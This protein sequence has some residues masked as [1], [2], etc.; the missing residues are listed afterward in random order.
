VKVYALQ[1]FCSSTDHHAAALKRLWRGAGEWARR[2]LL[3]GACSDDLYSR[4]EQPKRLQLPT[5]V[6][7]TNRLWLQMSRCAGA[8]APSMPRC[9]GSWGECAPWRV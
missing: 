7:V 1:P 5:N 2:E 6:M 9:V 8:R 3:M 4:K